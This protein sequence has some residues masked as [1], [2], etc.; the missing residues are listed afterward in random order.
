[1][2]S[3]SVFFQRKKFFTKIVNQKRVFSVKTFP[4]KLLMASKDVSLLDVTR[5]S[6][7]QMCHLMVYLGLCGCSSAEN[8]LQQRGEAGAE[9]NTA[10]VIIVHRSRYTRVVSVL[11]QSQS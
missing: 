4:I 5:S 10:F 9:K 1:M 2:C 3:H 11:P 8:T 7:Y 6:R